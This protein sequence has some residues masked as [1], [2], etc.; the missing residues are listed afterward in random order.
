[1]D[2]NVVYTVK[3]SEG[4]NILLLGFVIRSLG[5]ITLQIGFSYKKLFFI[6]LIMCTD[7]AHDQKSKNY[8]NFNL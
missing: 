1:M 4:Y 7:C 8:G 6:L 2:F 5:N 3:E